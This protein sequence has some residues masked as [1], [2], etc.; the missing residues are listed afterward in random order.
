MS[1]ISST[2]KELKII[3]Q[4]G[5]FKIE[6]ILLIDLNDLWFF[7]FE[8]FSKVFTRA[9]KTYNLNLTKQRILDSLA[10]LDYIETFRDPLQRPPRYRHGNKWK[11]FILIKKRIIKHS[12]S[13][14]YV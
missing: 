5:F 6:L 1:E 11:E 14:Y 10:W 12:L 4:Y 3:N 2:L 13:F 7:T 8:E 9:P